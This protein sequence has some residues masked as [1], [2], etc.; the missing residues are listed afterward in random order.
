MNKRL[1]PAAAY[2]VDEF[3]RSYGLGRS[4]L[5]K[6]WKSGAGPRPMHVGRRTFISV[7]AAQE[8]Q[9]RMEGLPT[10]LAS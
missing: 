7:E 6:L 9:R 8:W 10:A 4:T 1:L 5:Y 2:S 3:C